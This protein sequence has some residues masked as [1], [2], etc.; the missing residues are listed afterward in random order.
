M[1]ALA[2]ALVDL[3]LRGGSYKASIRRRPL[4]YFALFSVSLFLWSAQAIYARAFY[5]AGNTLVPMVAGTRDARF[6]AHLR[7]AVSSAR[8]CGAWPMASDIGIAIQTLS[9]AVLLHQRRMVSLASLDYRELGRCLAP[10][11]VAE[12]RSGQRFLEWAG[13]C[14]PFSRWMDALRFSQ[15]RPALAADR[16]LAARPAGISPAASTLKRLGM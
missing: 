4:A 1:I 13:G 16:R 14:R 6:A 15:G 3:V 10:E 12:R 2:P 5:A 7:F 11:L 8:H 9:L